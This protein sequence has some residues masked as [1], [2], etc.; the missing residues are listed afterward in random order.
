ML[1]QEESSVIVLSKED[2]EEKKN[3]SI[4]GIECGIKPWNENGKCIL[5]FSNRIIITTS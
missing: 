5:L 4:S 2:E 3:C 1:S